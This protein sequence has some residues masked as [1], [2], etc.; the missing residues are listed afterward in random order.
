[1]GLHL[2]I[3]AL[4]V[5]TVGLITYLLMR[6]QA[7][8]QADALGRDSL[9]LRLL[10]QRLKPTL[11]LAKRSSE[12]LLMKPV[13]ERTKRKGGLWNLSKDLMPPLPS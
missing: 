7:R 4:L 13:V 8:L 10:F 2:I 3:A 5:A 12:N 6:N 9:K 11:K 1:M